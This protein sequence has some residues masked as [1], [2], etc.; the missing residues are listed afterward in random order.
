MQHILI[1]EGSD[2]TM[3]I[4]IPSAG[5]IKKAHFNK[6]AGDDID[7]RIYLLAGVPGL[8]PVMFSLKW[9]FFWNGQVCTL[10]G[11]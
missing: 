10:F 7:V 8:V 4:R 9:A 3:F 5:A 2:T 6:E 1:I 11:G